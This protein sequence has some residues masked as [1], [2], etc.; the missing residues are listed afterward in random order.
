LVLG[1]VLGKAIR[2][3][4]RV[5]TPK[6]IVRASQEISNGGRSDNRRYKGLRK[7]GKR[8]EY[9][10]VDNIVL[11]LISSVDIYEKPP[12]V[13]DNRPAEVAAEAAYLE[14]RAKTRESVAAIE[15]LVIEV[16]PETTA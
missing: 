3:P 2:E 10:G 15:R 14:R 12:A 1:L 13:V 11:V 9:C 8:I 7:Q 5:L 16:E 6:K 4:D